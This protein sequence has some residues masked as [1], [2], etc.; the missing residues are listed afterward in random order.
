M[1]QWWQ[2][3][4]I[5]IR[6]SQIQMLRLGSTEKMEE[7]SEQQSNWESYTSPREG[8]S[9]N[10]HLPTLLNRKL[11]I[12]DLDTIYEECLLRTLTN[13]SK[14]TM[15]LDSIVSNSGSSCH[16]LINNTASQ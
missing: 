4:A 8:F 6:I 13:D 12:L 9:S 11:S 3:I 14:S 1:Y 16:R 5:A 10:E 15:R 2:I 7:Q